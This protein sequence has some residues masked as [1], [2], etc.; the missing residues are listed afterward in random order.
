MQLR[1]TSLSVAA[2]L[3]V[4]LGSSPASAAVDAEIIA[5]RAYL[6]DCS[7]DI[8]FRAEDAG[9]YFVNMWDDGSFRAGAGGPV[10][11][12]G[13]GRVRFTIGG[14]VATGAPGIG[15][16][17]E[18]AVGP[19][20]TESYDAETS[21]PWSEPVGTACQNAGESWAAS[22]VS[23]EFPTGAKLVLKDAPKPSLALLSKDARV[24]LGRGTGSPDDPVANGGS[25][26]VLSAAGAPF[27]DTYALP[28]AG[29]RLLS[30]SKPEAGFR[31]SGPSSD[32]IQSVIVKPGKQ[33]KIKGKGSALGHDLASDPEAVTVE[34]RLG[35]RRYCIRFGGTTSFAAGSFTAESAPADEF[36]CPT[37]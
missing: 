27:D 17:V 11:A 3:G 33:I 8:V 32:A 1:G 5:V 12:G 29:W 22:V 31:Y 4:W 36:A 7:V 20:A 34:L 16:Y 30:A 37:S 26:R 2:A 19:A 28:A 6:A 14:P 21:E 9:D 23:E 24:G 10:P 13:I 25:L 15:I 18:N 35:E